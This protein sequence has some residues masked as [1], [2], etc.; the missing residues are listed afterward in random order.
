[1]GV[2]FIDTSVLKENFVKYYGG[3]TNGLKCFK[4]CFGILLYGAGLE[5]SNVPVGSI[6]LSVGTDVIIRIKE[7]NSFKIVS[8]DTD[9]EFQCPLDK[10]RDFNGDKMPKSLFRACAMLK[11]KIKG[12][13]ILI[14]YSVNDKRFKRP[15]TALATAIGIMDKGKM[16]EFEMMKFLIEDSDEEKYSVLSAELYGRKNTILN[17]RI[18]GKFE[19]LPFNL[20]GL[21]VVI[22]YVDNKTIDI[23]KELS[24]EDM[25]KYKSNESKRIE[26]IRTELT[27]NKTITQQMSNIFK[28][29]ASELFNIMGKSADFLA[30]MYRISEETGLIKAVVPVY[31]IGG[32]C[33]FVEDKEIDQYV[34]KLSLEY[35][36]KAGQ[37]P[38]FCIC[39]SDS[40]GI[41]SDIE[42]E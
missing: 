8:S 41:I 35:Q 3:E 10:L 36:K 29:S 33:A 38:T 22:S 32:I 11:G 7:N 26:L 19:Y 28:T 20:S 6:S 5:G 34:E 24:N 37:M 9:T 25:E 21:K 23:K 27:E 39:D 40:S 18:D 14:D 15:I 2:F 12:G 30:D 16:P 42:S 4:N 17:R 31:S 13:E 1:M